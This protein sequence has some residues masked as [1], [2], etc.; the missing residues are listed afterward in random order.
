MLV[1][2]HL[3]APSPE[4]DYRQSFIERVIDRFEILDFDLPVARFYARVWSDLRRQ[5][6][7]IAPHDLMIGSTALFHGYDVLTHNVRDFDRI[8]G[9]RIRQPGW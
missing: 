5:G 2:V 4:R 7:V 1:G 8:S 9:L 6:N 3:A